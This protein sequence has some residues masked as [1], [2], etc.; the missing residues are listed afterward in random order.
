VHSV[1]S[2]DATRRLAAARSDRWGTARSL[3][4]VRLE[5]WAARVVSGGCMVG[6]GDGDTAADR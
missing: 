4:A 2:R 5:R 1:G 3:T 6:G